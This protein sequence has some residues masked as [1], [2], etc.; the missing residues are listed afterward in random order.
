MAYASVFFIQSKPTRYGDLEHSAQRVIRALGDTGDSA[1]TDSS[2]LPLPYRPKDWRRA[3][4][5]LY[6]DAR[7]GL[8]ELRGLVRIMERTDRGY[9]ALLPMLNRLPNE[10]LIARYAHARS[11]SSPG[12]GSIDVRLSDL[13]THRMYGTAPVTSDLDRMVALTYAAEYPERIR[14]E[15]THMILEN[16][17]HHGISVPDASDR[18]VSRAARQLALNEY[19]S[20][21]ERCV[22]ILEPLTFKHACREGHRRGRFLIGR[23][24]ID[25]DRVKAAGSFLNGSGT[26]HLFL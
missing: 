26:P 22:G 11:I 5:E 8:R 3:V 4:S 19:A 9:S 18:A 20:L 24:R 10:A 15:R 12:E 6:S 13:D 17:I 21:L 16:A 1:I 2:V 7:T 23:A 14:E 25:P